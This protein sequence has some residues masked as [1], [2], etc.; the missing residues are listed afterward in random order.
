MPTE[1]DIKEK[2]ERQKLKIPAKASAGYTAASI[3][4]KALGLAFTPLFTHAMSGEEYGSYALYMTVLGL[5]TTLCGSVFS[6]SVMYRGYTVFKGK[7]DK[8]TASAIAM[9]IL[10]SVAL[11]FPI[12]SFSDRIGLRAGFVPFL[13]LQ[14][15]ADCAISAF[16]AEKRYFY[17]YKS[18]SAITVISALGGPLVSLGLLKILSGAY[19]RII[20]LLI[21]SILT[22]LPF[23][24][25]RAKNG[26]YDAKM[27]KYL[28][29]CALPLIPG[30]VCHGI[31]AEADKLTIARYL[32]R[33]ALAAYTVAHSIGV[34]LT[35][36]TGSL[37]SA[38]FPWMT[39]KLKNGDLTQ[40]RG[41][42]SNIYASLGALTVVL[43]GIAPELL[44]LLSPR[45]Y[46]AALP[47]VFPLAMATLPSFLTSLIGIIALHEEKPYRQSAAMILAGVLNALLNIILVPRFSYFGA[48]LA[49]LLSFT[50]SAALGY[51]LSRKDISEYLPFSDVLRF[52]GYTL[53]LS[54]LMTVLYPYPAL[55]VLLFSVPAVNLIS[56][57]LKMKTLILEDT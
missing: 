56:Y 49:L 17:S 29:G 25:M 38:L 23:L 7:E 46:S 42:V 34:G 21:I 53:G 18:A 3:T 12:L 51:Y 35:F 50:A 36:L 15:T 20:G 19:S 30:A 32:G 4:A 39:R 45:S 8:F 14:L 54:A 33:E 13:L 31:V 16:L 5:I 10:F 43:T 57:A 2:R 37:G 9:S 41:T 47:S 52:S 11:C 55:R 22:A 44:A 24:I 28:F 26:L 48:G 40:M 6:G 1:K 27:W